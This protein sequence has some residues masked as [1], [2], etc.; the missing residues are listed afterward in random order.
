LAS[1]NETRIR[2]TIAI[3]ARDKLGERREPGVGLD[4]RKRI[5]AVDQLDQEVAQRPGAE[6]VYLASQMLKP[7]C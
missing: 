5:G 3:V 2:K 1:D 7:H 4:A 6:L